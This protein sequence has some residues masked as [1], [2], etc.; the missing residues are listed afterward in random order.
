MP[1]HSVDP[2]ENHAFWRVL[3]SASSTDEGL[4]AAE[5]ALRLATDGPNRIEEPAARGLVVRVLR[6]LADPLV[7]ILIAAAAVSGATGDTASLVIILVIVAFSVGL[8]V[9]QEHGAERAA[10]ALRRSIAL[11]VTV[12]RDGRPVQLPAE[13]VVRGDVCRLAPGNLVPADGIVLASRGAR[14]DESILTGEPWPAEKRPGPSNAESL[15]DA[16]DALFAGTAMVSGEATMLVAATGRA[17]CLGGISADLAHDEPPPAFE[18]GLRR[19][20]LLIVRLTLALVLLVLLAQFLHHRPALDALMFAAALAVGLTPELLPMVTTVTLTRG[21]VR[22]ARR[23]VIVKR[24][25]AIHDLGAMDVLCTDKTG[26]LTAARIALT[27]TLAPDGAESAAVRELAAVNSHYASGVGNPLD[28]AILAAAPDLSGWTRVAD[29]PFDFER[30][31]SAV[32]AERDGER[33]LIVKGAPEDVL[34]LC[35]DLDDAARARATALVEAHAA[36]GERLLAVATRVMPGV[37]AVS[38]ADEAGLALAGFACF[39][40]PPKPSAAAAIA[41]LHGLGVRVKIVSGDAA[42]VVS[43]LVASLGIPAQ[44]LLTGAEIERMNDRTLRAAVA[45]HDLYA[46]VSPDQKL[47]VIHALSRAGHTVGFMGDGINDAPA[48]HAADA[49]LSVDTATDVA[50]AAADLILL[51]NDLGVVADGVEEGRRTYAN[52]MKYVRMGTSSNFG[53]MLSMA[54]ASLVVPFLPMTGVQILL[55]NLLYDLSQT[56]IPFDAVDAEDLA[57]PRNWSI[58]AIERFTAVMGP[59][60]SL[61]DLAT[62]ALLLLVFHAGVGEFRTAWF[63]ESM[64]TQLLVIFVIRTRGRPWRSRANRTLVATC[65]GALAAALLAAFGPWRALFGFAPL[66]GHL[67]GLVALLAAAYLLLAELLKRL[68]MRENTLARRRRA[69]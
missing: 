39:L 62:F 36:A 6:R 64:L 18:R 28:E 47:R 17:T 41:R 67:L 33:L 23:K 49:G 31:R 61:F 56:G 4:T 10:E 58:A 44:G 43:H 26:T 25:A 66:P 55:N 13:Q 53:N 7:L 29:L 54:V 65:L 52:I 45:R 11:R 46:R 21:A 42:P 37:T 9:V 68:A 48:I 69:A 34:A 57:A 51:D 16:F 30:R 59:L 50:R 15:A 19:L 14:V 1:H 35:T 32:L 5:A 22:M 40:D 3:P 60:S 12:L 27:A 38:H 20:G 2:V 63:V 24:L 8:D